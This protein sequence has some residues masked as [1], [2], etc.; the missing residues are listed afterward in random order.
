MHGGPLVKRWDLHGTTLQLSTFNPVITIKIII[1]IIV[2]IM[3]L[4]CYSYTGTY[5]GLYY[6]IVL[7]YNYNIPQFL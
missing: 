6:I 2:L 7:L 1:T 3:T 5:I 4:L